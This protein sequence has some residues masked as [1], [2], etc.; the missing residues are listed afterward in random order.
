[1]TL[2]PWLILAIVVALTIALMY[3]LLSRRFGWRVLGYWLV[4]LVGVL[5]AE[6]LAEVLGWNFSRVG[7]LRLVPDLA[8]ALLVVAALWFLGI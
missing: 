6:A 2:P 4:V 3:Q 1:V 7:D 8:G 5:G